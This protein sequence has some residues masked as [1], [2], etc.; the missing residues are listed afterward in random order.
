MTFVTLTQSRS[1]A[2]SLS[3][4]E[5]LSKT[6]QRVQDYRNYRTTVAE[7]AE[8]S[9]AQLADMGVHRS[10]IKRLAFEAV[11]GAED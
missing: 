2:L 4:A 6:V 10:E 11:Y 9:N 1:G 8:L 7:L 5:K 3:I